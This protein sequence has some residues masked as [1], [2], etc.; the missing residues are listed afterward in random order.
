[1]KKWFCNSDVLSTG[2]KILTSE[3]GYLVTKNNKDLI[4]GILP[5]ADGILKSIGAGSTKEVVNAVFKEA[6]EL[7]LTKVD[8]LTATAIAAVLAQ[9]HFNIGEDKATDFDV[10]L[11]KELIEAFLSG[12]KMV[13]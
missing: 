1:M 8:P 3:A 5:V 9:I 2:V 4:A 13:K 11:I 10:Q 7:L 12:V 6:V